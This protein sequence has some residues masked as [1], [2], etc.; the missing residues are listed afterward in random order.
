[1]RSI[2]WWQWLPLPWKKWRVV[3][4]VEAADEIPEYLPRR[5]AVLVTPTDAAT[6]IAF[7]C[8]CRQKHRVVLNLDTRRRPSWQIL[9]K[10]P[11]S[12]SPSIDD[13]RANRRC[14]YFLRG[15]RIT[16][17]TEDQIEG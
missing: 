8:P 1:M 10:E 17:V 5:G 13:V 12:L 7:D 15:G 6:W 14:H 16:W 4:H 11:L 3:L 9:N 2:R